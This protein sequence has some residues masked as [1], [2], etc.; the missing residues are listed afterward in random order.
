MYKFNLKYN[1]LQTICNS[2]LLLNKTEINS[3]H[4]LLYMVKKLNNNKTE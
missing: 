3:F 1:P 4:M 2:D